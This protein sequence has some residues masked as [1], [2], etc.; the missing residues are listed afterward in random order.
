L[1]SSYTEAA[2]I[3]IAI[4]RREKGK[5]I[6]AVAKLDAQL[7]WAF[8]VTGV[9]RNGTACVQAMRSRLQRLLINELF[10]PEHG[11]GR[12]YSAGRRTSK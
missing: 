12:V 8:E 11:P 2:D 1:A 6:G 9:I 5:S 4:E 10:E 7:A 3:R